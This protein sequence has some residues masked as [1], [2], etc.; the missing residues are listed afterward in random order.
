MP[1]TMHIRVEKAQQLNV[2]DNELEIVLSAVKRIFFPSTV[3]VYATDGEICILPLTC[4]PVSLS[5]RVMCFVEFDNAYQ[6]Q[7]RRPQLYNFTSLVGRWT[8]ANSSSVDN[9]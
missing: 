5:Q 3:L 2:D 7:V 8:C 9:V 4:T 6:A 1:C